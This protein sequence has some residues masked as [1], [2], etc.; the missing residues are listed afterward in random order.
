MTWH[1][2]IHHASAAG[3]DF[4]ILQQLDG[5]VDGDSELGVGDE[6]VQDAG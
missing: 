1:T 5:E 3:S 6:E 2:S 4:A